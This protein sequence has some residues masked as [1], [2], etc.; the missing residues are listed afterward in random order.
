MNTHITKELAS[1][2]AMQ[3]CDLPTKLYWLRS[4]S[5]Y[6][7]WYVGERER[8]PSDY[9]FDVLPAYT[10]YDILVTHAK[11]FWGVHAVE[12][13]YCDEEDYAWIYHPTEL[14]QILLFEN[15]DLAEAYIMEHSLFA[16]KG[17]DE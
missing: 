10:Y 7:E 8:R 12:S 17:K 2:L 13:H 15:Y 4:K 16:N 14:L 9:D 11:E 1:W 5:F 3:G 6:E